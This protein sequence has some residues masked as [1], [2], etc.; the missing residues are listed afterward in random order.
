MT[1][2]YD[3][4]QFRPTLYVLLFIGITGFSLA[5]YSPGV[6]LLATGALLLNAWL[7]KTGR[8]TPLPRL[9][10]NIVTLAAMLYVARELL[11]L[12]HAGAVIAIG[13]FLVLLQIVKLYEQRGNRDFAQLLVLSLLLMVAASISTASLA[14]GILLIIYLFVSLY[15]CLL[16]HLKVESETAQAAL[17]NTQRRVN[18]GTLRQDQRYLASSMRRLTGLVSAVAI[19]AAVLVFLF[20]PRN[21]GA[22]LLGNFQFRQSQTLTGF[23][24]EVSFQQVARITRNEEKVAD[25]Q[26]WRDDQPVDGTEVLMLRGI[27]LDT[28]GG[29]DPNPGRAWRWYRNAPEGS[30]V[31][32]QAP[33]NTPSTF[34]GEPALG[35]W[36]L[37]V[38]LRPTG[39]KVLFTRGG[40]TSIVPTREIRGLTYSRYDQTMQTGD[41]LMQPLDYTVQSV[42]RLALDSMDDVPPLPQSSIDPR[43]RQFA[44]RADVSG[45][46]AQGPLA[47]RRGNSAKP[48]GVDEQIARNIEAYL[49]QNFAYTLDLTDVRRIQ[50]QDPLVAFLYD[51]KRGH[52][53]YF[54]GAMALMCQSLGM[55]ARVVVGFKC[56]EY[57][58]LGHYYIV[59]QS[60]A[61]AWV[62]VLNGQGEW[63]TFD[64]TSAHEA[65]PSRSQG[66]LTRVRHVFDFLEYKWANSVV[67]YDA[68][69]RDSLI[70]KVGTDLQSTASRGNNVMVELRRRLTQ[71][72]FFNI[73]SKVLA[74]LIGLMVCLLFASVGWFLLERWRLRKLAAQIG[75]DNLP[76]ADQLRLARQLGFY[77]D[78]MALLEARDITRAKHQTPLEFTRSLT[79]LPSEPYDAIQRLTRIFYRIRFGD[80][81]LS[82]PQR[83]RLDTVLDRIRAALAPAPSSR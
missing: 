32:T 46:D 77:A 18:A 50:G 23:S 36:K 66:F 15:C 72:T 43:I 78:L 80:A 25:V 20:F 62:E 79:F 22:G 47:A 38:S 75:L 71:D 12:G 48:T 11:I 70:D 28:Y 26:L 51:F 29:D 16:F 56:D 37:R 57:N 55:H 76:A 1:Q 6:W 64:P 27:T 74:M 42:D 82:A 63:K 61:H 4:R 2:M 14:Y 33:A 17:A 35:L 60:H 21:T 45:S 83:R 5:A 59:K 8:F 19:S 68:E 3:I 49:Q 30:S 34:V 31:S 67:A 54:A 53:E 73:S 7:V 9:A 39:T 10:A 52:C 44:L 24:E 81:R 69:S 58:N 41:V 40:P 65:N 13:Q